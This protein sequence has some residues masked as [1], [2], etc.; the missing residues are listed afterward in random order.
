VRVA[1]AAEPNIGARVLAL[2]A[3]RGKRLARAALRH[4]YA[5][6]GIALEGGGDRR[7]P[8][9]LHRAVEVQRALRG[10]GRGPERCAEAQRRGHEWST[11]SN[12]VTVSFP[13]VV[14]MWR[15]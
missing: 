4:V 5:D 8:L 12:D 9:D 14:R 1:G 3:D 6:A 2:G 7:A 15:G 10:Y 13:A 11:T